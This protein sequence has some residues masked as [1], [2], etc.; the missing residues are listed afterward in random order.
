MDIP[1]IAYFDAKNN[2]K[3]GAET[4]LSIFEASLEK[5]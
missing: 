1:I 3:P 4:G 2:K 5:E